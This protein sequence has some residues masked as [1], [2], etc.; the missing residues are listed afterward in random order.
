MTALR[1]QCPQCDAE[2]KLPDRSLIGRRAKCPKCAHR[3]I[4][5]EPEEEIELEL[6][7]TSS[8]AS[9]VG[10]SPRWVPDSPQPSP[11]AVD[12]H[13]DHDSD[14]SG[15]ADT[16]GGIERLR[17]I[18]RKNARRRQW[19]VGLNLLVAV[20]VIGAFFGIRAY[21][22]RAPEATDPR[23][24]VNQAWKAEKQ[25]L[26]A[27]AGVADGISPTSGDPIALNFMPMGTRIIVHMHPAV[28][29][30][31]ERRYQEI[32]ACLGPIRDWLGQ[33]IRELCVYPPEEIEQLTVCVMLG[34][35]GMPADFAARVRL[36]QPLKESDWILKT[37]GQVTADYGYPVYLAGDRVYMLHQDRRTFAVGPA[38]MA[39]EMVNAVRFPNPT[40]SGIEE[41]LRE[42][43]A[44]RHLTFV[45]QPQD[46][47]IHEEELVSEPVRALLENFV[48]W[49]GEDVETVAWSLHA[50]DEFFSEMVLR[51]ANAITP[52]RLQRKLRGELDALPRELYES[53]QKMSPGEVGKRRVIGRYPAMIKAVSEATQA[54]I[55]TRFVQLTTLLPERATPNLVLGTVLTWDESTRTDFSQEPAPPP[56]SGE[57]VPEKIVDRLKKPLEIDF[58]RT[59]L[60][61]A[62][63]YI[64]E[65]TKAPIDIDGD[66]LKFAGYTKN[67]PQTFALGVVPAEEALE[68]ILSQYDQMCIVVDETKKVATVMTFAFAKDR[69]L[70]PTY[71][72]K[73]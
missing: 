36:D 30:K 66:A 9:A 62:F 17:E 1:I 33:Q 14:A 34:A 73:K 3:F 59:P 7:G 69:G 43:D 13:A 12:H 58:R 10:T 42:T 29:W 53:V 40:A 24:S 25:D 22:A 20:L 51:S 5:A 49:L 46:L 44:D 65:E 23:P 37:G 8:S 45:F 61:E 60:Q 26:E 32:A 31:P 15:V 48:E 68:K 64:A 54:G 52:A 4:V 56:D 21:H 19:T 63:A 6:A 2:L 35:K 71:P 70:T 55:G 57:K 50:G 39:E 16:A 28:L 27:Q 38:A 11:V 47:L 72:R 67:M 41:V 18:R